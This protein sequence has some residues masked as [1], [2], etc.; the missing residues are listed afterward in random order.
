MNPQLSQRWTTV[1][2]RQQKKRNIKIA[3]LY[4]HACSRQLQLQQQLQL[5]LQPANIVDIT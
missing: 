4:G 2:H 3:K 1:Q 5:H